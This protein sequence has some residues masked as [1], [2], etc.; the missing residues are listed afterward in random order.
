MAGHGL[1]EATFTLLGPR[2]PLLRSSRPLLSPRPALRPSSKPTGAQLG[3]PSAP[4]LPVPSSSHLDQLD[5]RFEP[6]LAGLQGAQQRGGSG[7]GGQGL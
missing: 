7:A 5:M 2:Q 3:P 6:I 4:L 1:G